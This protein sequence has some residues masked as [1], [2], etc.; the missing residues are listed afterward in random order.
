MI[1]RF[2]GDGYRS[3]LENIQIY[4]EKD[5]NIVLKLLQCVYCSR[6]Y[7][8]SWLADTKIRASNNTY[9]FPIGPTTY[10]NRPRSHSLMDQMPIYTRQIRLRHDTI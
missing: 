5:S 8:T 2:I 6:Q 9:Y 7:H 10:T 4:L 1:R 3:Q